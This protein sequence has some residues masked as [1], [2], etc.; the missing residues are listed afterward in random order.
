MPYINKKM[1]KEPIHFEVPMVPIGKG[2]PKFSTF[3]G[4]IRAI[5]PSKTRNAEGTIRLFSEQVMAGRDLFEGPVSLEI[6]AV[7][8]VPAS[9]SN[10][11]RQACLMGDIF[12]TK[13]PDIDNIAKLV[14]DSMNSV[15]FHD[16]VQVVKLN[17]RKIY[18]EKARLLITVKPINKD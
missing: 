18:G 9:Y 12:P 14:L 3:G 7:F 11:K 16:D 17:L 15:V 2:R 13:K 10:K 8:P 5:T 4:H 6:V 1:V